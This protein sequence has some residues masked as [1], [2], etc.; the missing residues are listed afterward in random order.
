VYL[1]TKNGVVAC[2]TDLATMKAFDGIKTPDMEITDR[3]IP[4][5]PAT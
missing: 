2:H 4:A 1:A 5:L 3:E